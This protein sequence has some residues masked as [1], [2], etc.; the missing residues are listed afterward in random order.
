MNSNIYDNYYNPSNVD[1]IQKL[2]DELSFLLDK[3]TS[4]NHL[5]K[6]N[7]EIKNEIHSLTEE[8]KILK[9][10]IEQLKEKNK[11][12]QDKINKDF[13]TQYSLLRRGQAFGFSPI[14]SKEYL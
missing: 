4:T 12:L 7:E 3:I 13:I 1:F 9:N 8:N 2:K 11:Q 6:E 14:L 10:E 5:I